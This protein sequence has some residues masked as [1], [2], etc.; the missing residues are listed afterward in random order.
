MIAAGNVIK[1]HILS[2]IDQEDYTF[3][4]PSQLIMGLR[5]VHI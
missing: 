1:I 3:H 5:P 4:D 2:I